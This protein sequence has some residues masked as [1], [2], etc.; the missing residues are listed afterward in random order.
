[1]AIQVAWT[2]SGMARERE[3]DNLIKLAD[4]FKEVEKLVIVTKA[5][6]E[7]IERDGKTIE[8]VPLYK[9]LLKAAN[10]EI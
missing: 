7:T 3:I 4:S 2:I 10:S 9:F 5:E 1:M 8:V 6:E